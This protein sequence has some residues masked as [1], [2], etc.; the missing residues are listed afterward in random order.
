MVTPTVKL[1]NEGP[2]EAVV[3]K[4]GLADMQPFV[5][6]Y[7]VCEEIAELRGE[8]TDTGADHHVAHP[9]AVLSRRVTPVTVAT[10]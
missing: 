7:Q 6:E 8:D 1:R 5:L 10:V 4:L 3:H 9:V 2:A